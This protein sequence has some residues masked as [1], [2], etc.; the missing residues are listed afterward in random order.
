MTTQTYVAHIRDT[1]LA[2]GRI[3][4]L[5]IDAKIADCLLQE[6]CTDD[7]AA[8]LL[9]GLLAGLLPRQRMQRSH[10]DMLCV[11]FKKISQRRT[12]LA[13]PE[14]VRAKRHQ[15]ARNPLRKTLRQN[16]HIIRCGD[17]R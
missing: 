1:A 13:A 6:L 9:I 5:W 3:T 8:V 17:E 2:D 4:F 7:S 14:T 15:L 16:L 10:H 12:I 11:H